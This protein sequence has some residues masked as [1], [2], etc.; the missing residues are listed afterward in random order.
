L[1]N[2]VKLLRRPEPFAA[3]SL[4]SYFIRLADNNG[5]QRFT[6]MLALSKT[7]LAAENEVLAKQLPNNLSQLNLYHANFASVERYKALLALS[8]LAL[9]SPQQIVKL[10]LLRGADTY[11]KG[12][13]AVFRDGI[14][15]P[16]LFLRDEGIP[17]CPDCL[18]ESPYIR[19]YWHFHPHL[20]CH[21]H[22]KKLLVLCPECGATINYIKNLSITQCACGFDLSGYEH[23]GRAPAHLIMLSSWLVDPNYQ[24]PGLD[25]DTLTQRWGIL[26]WWWLENR[27]QVSG[28]EECLQMNAGAFISTVGDLLRYFDK[29]ITVELQKADYSIRRDKLY[30]FSDM[31][32]DMLFN[33]VKLPSSQL[34]SNLVLAALVRSI[35]QL[36]HN[37][38]YGN[39]T[40]RIRLNAI[41]AAMFLGTTTE[42]VAELVDSGYLAMGRNR[43]LHEGIKLTSPQFAL[44]D[45]IFLWL[46]AFQSESSN[47]N[48]YLSRW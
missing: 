30:S 17:V 9:K 40:N 35:E 15:Y 46:S 25:V 8:R 3:E 10:A 7:A 33:A 37:S 45:V 43:K 39:L 41:E 21:R 24:L 1:E 38:D 5:Y 6:T 18:K 34:S 48:I 44:C 32:G 36:C 47:R 12:L 27:G 23:C 13:V 16:R 4:E 2:R 19:Q 29:R 28:I 42:Q 26:L 14:T 11:S 31:F 20:C 22:G